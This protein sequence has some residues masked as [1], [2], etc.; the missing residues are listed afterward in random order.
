LPTIATPPAT[1]TDRP[2]NLSSRAVWALIAVGVLLSF[3][4]LPHGIDGDGRVR[5]A[6]LQGWLG[7]SGVPNTKYQLIGSLPSV[8]LMLLGRLIASPEWWVSRYNV[9]VYAAGIGLLY[10]MLRRHLAADVLAAFLLLLGT[11]AMLPNSLMGFGAETFTVMAAGTGLLA[12]S[13]GRWKT[14][15]LLLGLAIA[16]QP[17]TIVGVA[18]ALGWWAWRQKR[19]RALAPLVIGAGLWLVENTVRR[20]SPFRTG[21][22]NDHGF[23]TLLPYSGLTGFSYPRFFGV[24]SLLISFGKGLLFFAPGLVLVFR[25]GLEA[26][27]TVKDVLI[28]WL[29]Y[30]GGLL[31]VYGG[32]WAWYGGG[33]WGPRFLLFASLPASLLLAA[34]VRRPPRA[35][36]PAAV[37]L[38]ALVLS[39]WVGIDGQTFGQFGQGIC[40]ANNYSLESFCWYLPEFSVLWTP[41]VHNPGFSWRYPFLFAYAL[42]VVAYVS[43]P[44]LRQWAHS[45]YRDAGRAWS[46]YRERAAWRF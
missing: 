10:A 32:W 15:T 38:A 18:L 42:G 19:L 25:R 45:G 46:G 8:P 24:L 6:A 26:L 1:Q 43:W 31:L 37:V 34:Q 14:A 44:L 40:P 39:T 5:F 13:V 11:T 12:W 29:L 41:F 9:L 27:G 2:S 36:P 22:E 7:G 28:L 3:F 30:L 17:A 4:V 21:Y 33:T 16:N 35:F 23:Q 20:G